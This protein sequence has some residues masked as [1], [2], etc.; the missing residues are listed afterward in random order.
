LIVTAAKTSSGD[1]PRFTHANDMASVRFG[2]GDVPGLK[3]VPIATGTPASMKA[4]AGAWWSFMRNQV[5]TGS[6][7]A[8]TGS[9]AS[10]TAAIAAIPSSDGVARWSADAASSSAASS[11]PPDGASSSAWSRGVIP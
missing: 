7:V 6:S 4:R 10:A 8:T 2:V 9:P 11:A 3:S 1:M 5:V